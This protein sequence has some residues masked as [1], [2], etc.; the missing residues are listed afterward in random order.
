M[1]SYWLPIAL[2]GTFTAVTLIVLTVNAVLA[3]RR[4]AVD[5]LR[6]Q[7]KEIGS[8][9]SRDQA[10][11]EPFSE[12]VVFPFVASLGRMAKR[13][14][15]LGMRERIAR[16][17]VLAGSPPGWDAEKVAAAKIFGA[18]GGMALGAVLAALAGLAGNLWVLAAT[19]LAA[20]GYL[21]P[22]AGLGQK[23]INRQEDIQRALPDTIDLLTIS[24]EAGL[25]FDAALAH[26]AKNVSGPLSD[27]I[28]RMLQEMQLGVSRGDAF[29]H[30]SDR[31]D[32]EELRAFTMSMV[33]ADIF[34]VSIANVLRAQSKEL[35]IR[36]RQ[37]AEEKA[38]KV[39][40]KLLFPLIF[41]ILPAMFLAI[42]GPGIIQ[43][44]QTLFGIRP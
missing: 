42:L 22:G 12:R 43:I 28:S 19:F 20:F 16:K 15:P 7:V 5:F 21:V 26:V 10:L 31:T 2:L 33:Q 32:L 36:R 4:V 25:G 34:G 38:I 29:R 14:T 6:S 30:L 8:V 23:A 11:S 39:P 24:V 17:L 13:I 40:V 9:D 3:Q 37:R 18:V 1:S 35:R 41:G 44:A 27:E